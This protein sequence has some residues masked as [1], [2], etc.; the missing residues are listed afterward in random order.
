MTRLALACFV[1]GV[2]LMVVFD[3][4]WLGVILLFAFIVAGVFAIADPQALSSGKSDSE[5]PPD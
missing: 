3:V 1:V 2:L 4:I 5:N